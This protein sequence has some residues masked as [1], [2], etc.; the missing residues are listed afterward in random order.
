MTTFGGWVTICGDPTFGFIGCSYKI[1]TK[2]GYLEMPLLGKYQFSKKDL[3]YNVTIG[4]RCFKFTNSRLL[5]KSKRLFFC[6]KFK[7][8]HL[9]DILSF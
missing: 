4:P 8:K 3:K 6:T 7:Q 2:V 5:I 1:E 9:V